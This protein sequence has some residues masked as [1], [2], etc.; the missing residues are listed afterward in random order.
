M[1]PSTQI[2]C[3]ELQTRTYII[4]GIVYLFIAGT[5]T[6]DRNVNFRYRMFFLGA[7]A[8]VF[9]EGVYHMREIAK[10]YQLRPEGRMW[11]NP[12]VVYHSLKAISGIY[13]FGAIFGLTEIMSAIQIMGRMFALA[14]RSIFVPPS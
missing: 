7:F 4:I 13:F 9:V 6:V 11:S 3:E 10:I 1:S 2:A 8:Y 14:G 12:D 5:T